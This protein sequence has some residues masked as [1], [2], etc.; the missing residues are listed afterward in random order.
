VQSEVKSWES[1]GT[2]RKGPAPRPAWPKLRSSSPC[3]ALSFAPDNNDS[4]PAPP[5]PQPRQHT[6]TH[7]VLSSSTA[8]RSPTATFARASSFDRAFS[9]F[10]HCHCHC[11]LTALPLESSV[12][13]LSS[14][15]LIS[16]ATRSHLPHPQGNLLINNHT[17]PPCLDKENSTSLSTR[18]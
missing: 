15:Q 12:I 1:C 11:H 13:Y 7:N 16:I 4:P 14:L 5:P 10:G 8:R 17:P 6:T 9:D 18:S 3:R 2:L